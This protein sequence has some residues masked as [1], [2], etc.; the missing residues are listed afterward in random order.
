MARALSLRPP[1]APSAS[2]TPHAPCLPPISM[3]TACPT[4]CSIPVPLLSNRTPQVIARS[5]VVKAAVSDTLAAAPALPS[6]QTTAIVGTNM[7]AYWAY[8]DVAT[9]YGD[10]GIKV[11]GAGVEYTQCCRADN[12]TFNIDMS[13]TALS[14]TCARNGN[15]PFSPA[16]F[17]GL[18]ISTSATLAAVSLSSSTWTGASGNLC[19]SRISWDSNHIYL[20]FSGLDTILNQNITLAIQGVSNTT[21]SLSV[22]ASSTWGQTVSLTASVSPSTATGTMT[23]Y[24]NGSLVASGNVSS[25]SATIAIAG[26][27]VGSHSFSA[28]YG[29]D[30]LDRAS[31]SSSI[32]HTVSKATASVTLGSLSQTWDNTAK[33]ATATTSP[34]NLSVS[35]TYNGSATA[36]TAPCTYAV[37][38]TVNDT[39][40]TGTASGNLV[41]GK[42]SATVVLSNL[43]PT[44]DN[45]AKTATVTTTP[46][47]LTVT[48][49]YNGSATAP[50]APGT[51]AVVATV[52]DTNYTGT[53]TVTLGNLTPT[54]DN[55]AK[56]VSVTT[57]PANLTVTTTYNG[58]AT[59]PHRRGVVRRCDHRERHE[60]HR[61]GQRHS[62]HREGGGHRHAQ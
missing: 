16:T 60:L 27:S 41:I 51:Y 11:V 36:P 40:Y 9:V 42:A 12:Q 6:S 15:G 30:S 20:N 10:G 2:K 56:S 33:S 31:S 43:T 49:T 23:F 46:A 29:G 39:H 45:T 8:P 44:W 26:F 19:A 32:S 61:H 50:T 48:I 7:S 47:N 5:T 21:T 34:A 35:F 62:R 53:A 37:V 25:G 55:T 22:P 18:V 24:D 59:A 38:A 57:T 14:I 52:N 13:E 54:Y 17:N 28:T 3:R 1:E 4:S 58:S